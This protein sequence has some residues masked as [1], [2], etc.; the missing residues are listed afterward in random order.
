[1][2]QYLNDNG[3][4]V[5]S[6]G[7][8][9]TKGTIQELAVS[10]ECVL[11]NLEG[12]EQVSFVAH[13]MGNIVIRHLLYRL[14]QS[15]TTMP[16]NLTFCRLVMISPPNQAAYLADTIGQAPLIQSIFGPAVDQFAATGGWRHLEAELTI[17]QFEFG[18]IAGGRGNQR[19]YLARVPGDD[20]GLLAIDSHYLDGAADFIQIGGIHQLMPKYKSVQQATAHFLQHGRFRR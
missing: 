16:L 4:E 17:P 13:S 9:S 15:A 20:D 7:Y 1:M 14:E 19:G 8:A 2:E 5:V 11:R 6:F 3:F 12:V 18:I 10:L